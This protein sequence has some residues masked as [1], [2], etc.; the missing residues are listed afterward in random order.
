MSGHSHEDDATRRTDPSPVSIRF[1]VV[2]VSDRSAVGAREDG[3][4]PMVKEVMEA[5]L[6]A[7]QVHYLVIPDERLQI[8]A[9][10]RR[11]CDDNDVDVVFTSGGTGLAPRDVTPEATLD[12]IDRE[13]PGIVEAIRA[14]GL[15]KTPHAMLSRAVCGQRGTTLIINLS[16]SPRAV[17][18]QLEIVLPALPHAVSVI[19]GVPQDCART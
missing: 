14:A 12:V 19:A 10:L 9:A 8:A 13:I 18:E 11:L 16:G 3:S 15:A 17:R 6:E 5:E 4:G 2:T 1:A 7:I